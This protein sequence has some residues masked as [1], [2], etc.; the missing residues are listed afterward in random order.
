M[1]CCLMLGKAKIG[2]EVIL[3]FSTSTLHNFKCSLGFG[4][5]EKIFWFLGQLMQGWGYFC[6]VFHLSSIVWIGAWETFHFGS[7]PWYRVVVYSWKF[8]RIGRLN[9]LGRPNGLH[10]AAKKGT[11]CRK[12][13]HLVALI[14]RLVSL[15]FW[16]FSR[17]HSK[18]SS[19]VQE[20]VMQ[21][22]K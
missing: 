20:K 21:S 2:L 13:S 4:I 9:W 5:P 16:K 15:N 12:N 1:K 8:V 10:H 11:F 18:C 3:I 14:M 22:S 17:R 6:N 7:V 19:I